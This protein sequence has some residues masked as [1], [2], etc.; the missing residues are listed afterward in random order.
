M[1]NNQKPQIGDIL[2][3][4]WGYDAT[5]YNFYQVVG[6][7]AKSLKLQKL[8]ITK[9]W[10]EYAEY[11]EPIKNQ[12]VGEVFTRRLK[13]RGDWWSVKINDYTYAQNIW[14]GQSLGQ[15]PVGTY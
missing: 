1:V 9:S 3:A 2:Y 11:V 12:F 15:S 7:T 6:A 14:T 4:S 5:F 10:G 8:E 13:D